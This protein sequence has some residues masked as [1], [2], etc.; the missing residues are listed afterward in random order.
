MCR[1]RSTQ[2]ENRVDIIN[3]SSEPWAAEVSCG[4]GGGVLDSLVQAGKREKWCGGNVT[5]RGKQKYW[6]VVHKQET[7]V[8]TR[9]WNRNRHTHTIITIDNNRIDDTE[10]KIKSVTCKKKKKKSTGSQIVLNTKTK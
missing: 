4:E 6:V 9:D 10:V 3:S 1:R 5:G 8:E 7:R 2:D